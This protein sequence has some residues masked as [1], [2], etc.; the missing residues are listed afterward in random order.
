MAHIRSKCDLKKDLGPL[1]QSPILLPRTSV[2]TIGTCIYEVLRRP[3]KHFFQIKAFL[4]Y[5]TITVFHL[6]SLVA[7][8]FVRVEFRI[9]ALMFTSASLKKNTKNIWNSIHPNRWA[10]K[11]IKTQYFTNFMEISV[12]RV[13]FILF[14]QQRILTNFEVTVEV[15]KHIN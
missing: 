2:L 13:N 15:F 12:E 4:I 14:Q 9:F 3:L 11:D 6:K 5:S 8:R 7:H 10:I 1:W